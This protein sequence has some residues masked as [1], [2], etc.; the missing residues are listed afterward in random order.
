LNDG[1]M[2]QQT[3]ERSRDQDQPA[4]SPTLVLHSGDGDRN[5]FFVV[6]PVYRLGLPH[7]T[8]EDRR[9]N[10]VGYVQGVFQTGVLIE[11]V[12]RT[13]TIPGGLDLYFFAA[14]SEGNAPPLHF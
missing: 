11:T 13:T 7:D 9:N 4:S 5:G 14:D 10:L 2:R 3:L 6:L 8:V 12:L 1:G